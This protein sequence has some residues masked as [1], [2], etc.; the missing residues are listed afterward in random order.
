MDYYKLLGV[1]RNAQQDEI[2][3]KYRELAM[4]YHPDKNR[5][6]PSAESTFKSVSQA[7]Q[8]LSDKDKRRTY[9]LTGATDISE[10]DINVFTD[11]FSSFRNIND[12]LTQL[13]SDEDS[14]SFQVYTT[15][16][17]E[18]DI[19]NNSHHE[20]EQRKTEDVYYNIYATLEDIYQA[21]QKTITVNH[22]RNINN[23]FKKTPIELSIDLSKR[24]II[25]EG[26]ADHIEGHQPGN[27]IVNIFAKPHPKFKRINESDLVYH[28][29]MTVDQLYR[30]TVFKLV[31]L[32]GKEYMIK[33]CANTKNYEYRYVKELSLFI[34]SIIRFPEKFED[35]TLIGKEATKQDEHFENIIT[36][37]PMMSYDDVHKEL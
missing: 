13:M 28:H 25:F 6:D 5:N 27:I 20:E 29:E 9:D 19:P 24:D 23:R 4:K 14:I 17:F 21:K 33:L 12:I 32:D 36:A 11:M 1:E 10:N 31:H 34:H 37:E 18:F 15:M 16:P 26:Q 35:L 2:K 8:V 22:Y 3:R 30:D 7:Y